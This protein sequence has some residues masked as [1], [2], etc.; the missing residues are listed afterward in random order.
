MLKGEM[1]SKKASI[2]MNLELPGLKYPK[3]YLES[4]FYNMISNALKYS[5][6]GEQPVIEINSELADNKTRL[7]FKDNGIGIDLVRHS[8]QLFK[9][10]QTFHQGYD[11]K[12]IGLFMTKSQIE[13]FGGSISVKSQPGQGTEFT[14]II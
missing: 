9:L 11:S 5:K 2:I 3:V 1:L 12:G 7:T 10:H 13:T 14:I 6:K 4:I 8:N